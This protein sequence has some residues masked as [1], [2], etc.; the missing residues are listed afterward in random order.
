MR[1]CRG[2]KP[3]LK[4][5]QERM[6]RKDG[7]NIHGLDGCAGQGGKY[8]GGQLLESS[9]TPTFLSLMPNQNHFISREGQIHTLDQIWVATVERLANG[10]SCPFCTQNSTW[11]CFIDRL[12]RNIKTKDK[13][14]TKTFSTTNQRPNRTKK[15]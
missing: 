5:E 12:L 11:M 4:C 10:T 7:H 15:T 14:T 13:H 3:C 1:Q 8:K 2:K 6:F 9:A